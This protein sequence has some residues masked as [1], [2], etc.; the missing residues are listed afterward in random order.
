MRAVGC[1]RF[2]KDSQAFPA[3]APIWSDFVF[4]EKQ[5]S[6]VAGGAVGCFSKCC[7][8]QPSRPFA[9]YRSAPL[10]ST[11]GTAPL[12]RGRSSVVF[13]LAEKR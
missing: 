10:L 6:L 9:C 2:V 5:N 8:T 12:V 4:T 11:V 13:F 1:T 3:G 7:C